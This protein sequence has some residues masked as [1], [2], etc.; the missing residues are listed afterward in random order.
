MYDELI[1]VTSAKE[2][3]NPSFKTL[4]EALTAAS[5]TLKADPTA[6]WF[7]VIKKYLLP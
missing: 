4:V 2:A 7:V 1:L 3:N 5:K 6:A